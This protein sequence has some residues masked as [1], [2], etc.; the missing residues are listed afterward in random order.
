MGMLDKKFSDQLYFYALVDDTV[1]RILG[2]MIRWRTEVFTKPV[3]TAVTS[4]HISQLT[5]LVSYAY[6]T[7]SLQ[8]VLKNGMTFG[9]SLIVSGSQ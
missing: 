1:F 3:K 8:T 7:N 5:E 2:R 9:M 4:N 6:R